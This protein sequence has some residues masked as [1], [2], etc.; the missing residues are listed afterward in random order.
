MKAAQ[1]NARHEATTSVWFRIHDVC[2]GKADPS[3]VITAPVRFAYYEGLSRAEKRAYDDSDRRRTVPLRDPAACKLACK[4]ALAAIERGL[5][6]DDR[7]VVEEGTRALVAELLVQTEAPPVT[8]HV[9]AVRPSD[10]EGELHGYYE[11][12]DDTGLCELKVWMRTAAKKKPVALRSYV[13]TVLH[14]LCHHLDFA[15]DKLDYSF[16]THGFFARES[17]LARQLLGPGARAPRAARTI[18]SDVA[19]PKFLDAQLRQPRLFG[20]DD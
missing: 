5:L 17:D 13:R 4:D 12:D 3:F 9:L 18:N 10:D 8:V 11:M 7:A 15:R 14:E 16:H 6:A 2:G 1:D 20:T 19:R